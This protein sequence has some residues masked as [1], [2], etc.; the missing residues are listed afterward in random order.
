MTSPPP[1]TDDPPLT[2][3]LSSLPARPNSTISLRNRLRSIASDATFVSEASAR[4]A[5]PVVANERCGSWY[6]RPGTGSATAYF[7]STDGH[8]RAWKFSL[9]RLN[10]HLLGLAERNDGVDSFVI[11]DS[12]RRGKRMP[13]ALST[14]IPIW[15]SVMNQAVLPNHPLSQN[16]FLPPHLPPTI[17]SQIRALVP[18]FVEDL[19][20]LGLELSSDISKPLRPFWI[21]NGSL[22]P[23]DGRVI[24]DCYRP[25]VCCTASRYLADGDDGGG[26]K[27]EARGRGYVQGAADDAENWAF[28]LTPTIFWRHV[29]DLLATD[30]ADLPP[31]IKDLVA[32]AKVESSQQSSQQP[33]LR[34]LTPR[35]SVGALPLPS[36]KSR[37]TCYLALLPKQTPRDTW[38][39]SST[40]MEVGLGR[41]K[42]ASRNLRLALPD[43]C[44]FV[45]AFLSESANGQ[46]VIVCES[47]SDLSV[48][49]ALALSCRV[50]SDEAETQPLTKPVVK[51]RLAA[52][53]TAFPEA[54]PSRQTLQSVNSFLLDWLR[55]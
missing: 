12:T 49:T 13:D 39:Q 36:P 10:L 50:F 54:N 21:G 46:V 40:Q 37:D 25:V 27:E 31:L 5:R 15:C 44:A 28:G 18:G 33:S 3:I 38:L 16:V 23:D 51:A 26:E 22:L 24:F 41:Y 1:S 8:E 6:L 7:K 29:N 48:G 20:R 32:K 55:T 2:T 43:V 34:R 45:A 11:V 47:G 9:R 52:I 19:R 4:L 53:M 14:T 17:Q 35:L 30:E 42:T